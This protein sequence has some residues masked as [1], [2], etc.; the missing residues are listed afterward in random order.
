M[1]GSNRFR[2]VMNGEQ[3]KAGA[4]PWMVLIEIDMDDFDAYHCG[5][6]LISN[7]WIVTAAHCIR[8]TT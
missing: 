6:S 7:Q 2:R 4:D 8:Y 5:G 3:T 1:D